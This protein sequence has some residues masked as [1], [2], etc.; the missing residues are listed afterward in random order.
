M[1]SNLKAPFPPNFSKKQSFITAVFVGLFVGF[2][3]FLFKPFGIDELKTKTS[4][5]GMYIGFGVISFIGMLFVEIVIPRLFPGFFSES[6]YTVGKEIMIGALT[7]LVIALSNFSYVYFLNPP[8]LSLFSLSVMLWQTLLVG[9]FPLT[10][11]TLVKYTRLL[12]SNQKVSSEIQ[13]PPSSTVNSELNSLNPIAFTNEIDAQ[14]VDLSDLLYI[15]AVGNY[16]NVVTR[17]E[18]VLNRNLYRKTLKSIDEE[19]KS[20]YILRCHRSYI[21]NL[22]RVIEVN[23]NAQGLKLTLQDGDEV[24]P[25]SRKYITEVK[26]YFSDHIK[27]N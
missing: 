9:I 11:I 19:V 7:I 16:V 6:S 5:V 8:T 26:E 15:E 4:P 13:I 1:L 20:K 2:F 18:G 17:K 21:V 14:Q 22:E 3:L 10:L 27:Q 24:I 12:R 23:G 25:V